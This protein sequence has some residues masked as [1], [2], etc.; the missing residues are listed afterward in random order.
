MANSRPDDGGDP[1]S[2]GD[3]GFDGSAASRIETGLCHEGILGGLEYAAP[4]SPL[5]RCEMVGIGG[6]AEA[7]AMD[8]CG[9]RLEM[10]RSAPLP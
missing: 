3:F 7:R 5:S 4:G 6:I 2:G 9:A 1:G 8:T 10:V